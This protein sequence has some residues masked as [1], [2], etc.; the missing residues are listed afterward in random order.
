MGSRIRLDPDHLYEVFLEVGKPI[1]QAEDP[2]IL[3]IFPETYSDDEVLKSVPKFAFPTLSN[4]SGNQPGE[5]FAFVLTDIESRFKFGFCRISLRTQTC[6]CIISCLPWYEVFYP[7]LDNISDQLSSS[8]SVTPFLDALHLTKSFKPGETV[9]VAVPSSNKNFHF[10][11]PI[12]NQL[13]LLPDNKNLLEFC[14]C[15]DVNNMMIIFA[16]LL[17]ERRIL[18]YSQSL[19]RL[20]GCLAGASLL[21]HPMNW[22]HLYI[23]ILPSHLLDYCSAPMPYLIGL[24]SSVMKKVKIHELGDTVILNIDENSVKSEYDDLSSLPEDVVYSLK[25]HLKQQDK[26]HGNQP[27]KDGVSR[28]FLKAMVAIIG[29]YR[30]ALRFRPGE[31]ITFDPDAF[32]VSRPAH[33]QSLLQ[34]ILQLQTFQQF[35]SDRLDLLNAGEGFKDEFDIEASLYSDK[36]G[37]QSR[38]KD[39]LSHMKKQGKKLRREG[40][41]R[42]LEFT[43]KM[44]DRSRKTWKDL[45]SRIEEIKKDEAGTTTVIP[46]TRS[47]IYGQPHRPPRPPP[48]NLGRALGPVPAPRPSTIRRQSLENKIQRYHPILDEN[49]LA[50][51]VSQLKMERVSVDDADLNFNTLRNVNTDLMTDPDIQKAF[52]KSYSLEDFNPSPCHKDFDD[53]DEPAMVTWDQLSVPDILDDTKWTVADSEVVSLNSKSSSSVTGSDLVAL[54][55][56]LPSTHPVPLPRHSAEFSQLA[57]INRPDE[58]KPVQWSTPDRPLIVLDSSSST[59]FNSLENI[60]FDPLKRPVAKEPQ[61]NPS[62][63]GL[64]KIPPP[65]PKPRLAKNARRPDSSPSSS[66]RSRWSVLPS[67]VP[68]QAGPS[69]SPLP[70][71]PQSIRD[72]RAAFIQADVMKPVQLRQDSLDQFDPLA[73]G[74]LVVD[75]PSCPS[76]RQSVVADDDNLLKEWNLDFDRIKQGGASNA[77]VSA[78]AFSSMP[79][80][81]PSG[82]PFPGPGV[83]PQASHPQINRPVTIGTSSYENRFP[84]MAALVNRLPELHHAH[85]SML[86][87]APNAFRISAP[88]TV[89][90]NGFSAR[91]ATLPT[92]SRLPSGVYSRNTDELIQSPPASSV[93]SS[94]QSTL[95]L[96]EDNQDFDPLLASKHPKRDFVPQSSSSSSQWE[97]FD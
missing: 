31:P 57:S 67:P 4:D 38:Y 73:S 60:E 61:P 14:T 84:G 23:P 9:V 2:Y 42:W 40:K 91:S 87:P 65:V 29:G 22:Q 83:Y 5:H 53:E 54:G 16:S 13:S 7:L 82:Y 30:D 63:G 15:F 92:G 85:P 41:D 21:L 25:K 8:S 32:V 3:Q 97:K 27:T 28:A 46:N 51:D 52:R 10:A 20:T 18:A 45:A 37:T 90:N 69:S 81:F 34:K 70:F 39:W 26:A 1:Q 55:G 74:Q 17:C 68:D 59:S 6:L 12:P 76:S 11:C 71:N 64:E 80:L 33:M 94:V 58:V 75:M 48:P 62:N 66:A 36:W 24:H 95:N 43:S 78:A 56:G 19:C 35:V 88:A 86:R 79:S 44:R 89:A 96:L 72:A 77:P 49:S 47:N 93:L 50:D